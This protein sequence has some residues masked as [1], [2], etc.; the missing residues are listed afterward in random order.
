MHW[1]GEL[2]PSGDY[3]HSRISFQLLCKNICGRVLSTSKRIYWGFC[4]RFFS[5]LLVSDWVTISHKITYTT[6]ATWYIF[7]AYFTVKNKTLLTWSLWS[8]L[9][10]SLNFL[11]KAKLCYF[12]LFWKDVLNT[13]PFVG[14][15]G[16]STIFVRFSTEEE[17]TVLNRLCISGSFRDIKNKWIKRSNKKRMNY[18]YWNNKHWWKLFRKFSKF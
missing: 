2:L 16:V 5:P 6:M 7:G 11:E 15:S 4:T 14:L 8:R 12:V 17:K 18:K 1:D 10:S 3:V 9:Y 13:F